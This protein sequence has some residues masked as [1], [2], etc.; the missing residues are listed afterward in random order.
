MFAALRL[1]FLGLMSQ[2]VSKILAGAGLSLLS[3]G[4]ILIV[5]NQYVS[6]AIAQ[7][8]S[9]GLVAGL[10][11]LAKLDVAMSIIIGAI[12]FRVTVGTAAIKIGKGS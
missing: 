3:S 10:C 12:V 9:L 8:G 7:F 11:S 2:S 5:V 6:G 1:L 4:A